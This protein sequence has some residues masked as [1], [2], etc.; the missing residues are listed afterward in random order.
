M[1]LEIAGMTCQGCVRA[2]TNSL[3]RA[4]PDAEVAVDLAAKS[5]VIAGGSDEAAAREA[6]ERA[7]F[8]VIRRLD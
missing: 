2:V 5:V 1:K 4:L 3:K 8:T 7:G 6:I